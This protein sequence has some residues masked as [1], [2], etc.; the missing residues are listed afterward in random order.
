MKSQAERK[1]MEREER[2]AL[3]W[4]EDR[5]RKPQRCPYPCKI[6]LSPCPTNPDM[7]QQGLWLSLGRSG[8]QASEPR[9]LTDAEVLVG[10]RER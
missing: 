10:Q 4:L 3:T 9:R 6:T 1:V 7:A 5:I 2:E 8:Q